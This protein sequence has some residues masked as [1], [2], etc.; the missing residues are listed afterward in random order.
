MQLFVK[1][2]YVMEL[3]KD[4]QKLDIFQL[5]EIC[6]SCCLNTLLLLSSSFIC[7]PKLFC[8]WLVIL[9]QPNAHECE[10][11]HSSLKMM[12][13]AL[14]FGLLSGIKLEEKL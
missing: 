11:G 5:G 2:H 6:I 10:Q 13:D 8:D 12:E 1:C 4:F 3:W 9:K 7:F 14:E